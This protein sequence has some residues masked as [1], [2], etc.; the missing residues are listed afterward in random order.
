MGKA[1]RGGR[2]GGSD[3]QMKE[4]KREARSEEREG[5]ALKGLRLLIVAD[6]STTHTHRWARWARE[7]GAMVTVLSPF[8]DPIEGVRVLKFPAQRQWYHRIPK[9][10]MLLD[11]FPLRA[12]IRKIDPQ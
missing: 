1:E 11:L 3:C 8:A 12:L 5:G 2:G 9:A 4:E 6:S 10:R 7:A